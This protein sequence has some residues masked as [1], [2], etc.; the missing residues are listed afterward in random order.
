MA[1][2]R[3][4]HRHLREDRSPFLDLPAQPFM[5]RRIGPVD[6]AAQHGNRAPLRSKRTPVGRC[7]HSSREPAHH[8]HT[9][10]RQIMAQFFS[11]NTPGSRRTPG[12]H[13]RHSQLILL[14]QCAGD[15]QEWRRVRNH[16]Q[17]RGIDRAQEV[18]NLNLL[19][20]D[21]F[22]FP[23]DVP[24]GRTIGPSPDRVRQ[25]RTTSLLDQLITGS[26]QDCCGRMPMANQLQSRQVPHSLD[27][28]QAEPGL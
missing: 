3:R 8:R 26:L 13:N 2:G 21:G 20:L 16:L 1:V 11:Q 9:C 15:V 4:T 6:P 23:L 22:E 25:L 28:L 27:R 19:T 18:Q 24:T 14:R 10:R 12:P 17:S 5:F 7:V